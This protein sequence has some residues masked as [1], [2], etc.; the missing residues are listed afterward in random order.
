MSC[1]VHPIF[2]EYFDF[3]YKYV[4]SSCWLVFFLVFCAIGIVSL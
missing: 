2:G 4:V 1:S 3:R